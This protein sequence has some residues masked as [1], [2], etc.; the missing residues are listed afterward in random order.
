MPNRLAGATSPYL[1][2]HADN[3]VDWYEWGE[4][5]HR[6]AS[7]RDV[8][9]LLSVGYSACHWCHV[10]AHESF[11]D[12]ATAAFMNAHFVNVK[13]DR[14]E[15]P[16]VDRVYMDAVQ[17]MTGQGGW[18]MTVFLTPGGEPFFAGTYFPKEPRGS[19]PSF[20]QMVTRIEAAWQE[21]RP[22]IEQ[23][24]ERLTEAVRA[25]LPPA[26]APPAIDLLVSAV[27]GLATS[28]DREHGGF[29]SAPKFPQA[30][31]LEV[32]LRA[33]ALAPDDSTRIRAEEMLRLALDHMAAG[34][35]YD[36]L[37]GGFS[38]YAV[39]R[40][41]LVPH[42]EKMLYDNA[43]LA[44]VYLR[45]W[46]LTGV[47]RYRI[48][49][50]ETLE[51]LLRD[52]RHPGGGLFS[53]EDADSEGEEGKFY[54]W[55]WADLTAVLGDDVSTASVLF[56][57]T[58]R[59]NFEGSNI[60][61]RTEDPA[62]VANRLDTSPGSLTAAETRIRTAL[63]GVRD[64]RVRPGR[65]EKVVAAWNGLALRA[66]AEAG[67]I[68]GDDRYIEAGREIG[69]FVR[70]D[71][72][73]EGRLQRSWRDGSVSG[74]AFCDDH[75]AMACGLFAL[76]QATG[77]TEWYH[78]AER[79]V[80]E[81]LRL[82]SDQDGGFFA[83]GVDA[84]Q[85]IAR[86]KN[87]MDNPTPSDNALAAEALHTLAAYTAEPALLEAAEGVS[88]AAA[89]LVEQHPGAA[90]HLVAVLATAASGIKEVAIVGDPRDRA[91]LEA[92]VWETFRPDCVLA[93][94]AGPDA[95]IPLLQGRS[96]GLDHAVAFVCKNLTCDLPTAVPADLRDSLENGAS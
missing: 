92:V 37:G 87:L 1:Q 4:E 67:A 23:Q 14:E 27:D 17:A 75:A 31:N 86:P 64:R 10:M 8:P 70:K 85:L 40:I 13:V 47:D 39:D 88:R 89:R 62:A 18:P 79:L 83:T 78:D 11:E 19:F 20:M 42:F 96:G 60:L 29:G 21:Q 71:L 2:Q 9:I 77:E 52:M 30:P 36:H 84:D 56:G 50:I 43:L 66:L 63:L 22:A 76:F 41:W 49:A 32:L 46:Q 69:R 24:A 44:R 35:I 61:H 94:A 57:A 54:V 28:F 58:E 55:S 68:L 72:T 33:M 65:D 5:A 7:R 15:R 74:P 3:P 90:G 6:E 16:D 26:T 80:Q 51:Y 12:E 38:R 34:G 91:P 53:A 73:I 59:G 95:A 81:M 48:V 45:A 93:P 82:F 25:T